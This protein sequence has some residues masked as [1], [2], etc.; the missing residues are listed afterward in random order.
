MRY[1]I[2]LF[3]IDLFTIDLPTI[4]LPTIDLLYMQ[5]TINSEVWSRLAHQDSLISPP[6]LY[7]FVL[8]V[9]GATQSYRITL[10]L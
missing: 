2:G 7:F 3:T 4:D 6:P 8:K 9:S 1:S 10:R 5:Y